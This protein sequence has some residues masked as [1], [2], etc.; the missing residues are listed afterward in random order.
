MDEL[1]IETDFK[2][3]FFKQ[4]GRMMMYQIGNWNA[5]S[6]YVDDRGEYWT[7]YFYPKRLERTVA[8]AHHFV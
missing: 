2:I 5:N 8:H 4:T 7:I 6:I 3:W 1:K